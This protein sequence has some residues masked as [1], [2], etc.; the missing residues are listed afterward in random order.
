V[1]FGLAG[2]FRLFC[3]DSKGVATW[4]FL[5]I[6]FPLS[7]PENNNNASFVIVR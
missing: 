4:T 7:L 6:V 3:A 1:D 5:P 2:G